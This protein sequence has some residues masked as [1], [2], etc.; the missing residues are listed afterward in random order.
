MH[1]QTQAQQTHLWRAKSAF[2]LS[3]KTSWCDQM[4]SHIEMTRITSTYNYCPNPLILDVRHNGVSCSRLSPPDTE[5]VA[6]IKKMNR[7]PREKRA[8]AIRKGGV[9]DREA[10]R[11]V[12]VL[13]REEAFSSC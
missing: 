10:Q 5:C 1:V 9:R 7:K 12:S 8:E 4:R 6:A 3:L 11:E 13:S 2:C